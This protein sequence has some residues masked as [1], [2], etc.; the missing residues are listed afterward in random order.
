LHSTEQQSDSP[1]FE[2]Q[3]IT[4][5]VAFK[6]DCVTYDMICLAIAT[7]INVVEINEEDAGWD[8]F[9]RA[10]EGSL[11]GFAPADTWLPAVTLPAFAANP[12]T[13]FCKE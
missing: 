1:S 6:N 3:E 4:T 8:A 13:I 12:T 2:W 10:A 5:V 9:I 7:P 11:P